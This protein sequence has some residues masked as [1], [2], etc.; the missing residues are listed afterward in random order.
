M[1]KDENQHHTD[2]PGKFHKVHHGTSQS[3][4]FVLVQQDDKQYTWISEAFFKSV[5]NLSYSTLYLNNSPFL[6]LLS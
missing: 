1:R 2:D 3:T 6:N 4:H 5:F